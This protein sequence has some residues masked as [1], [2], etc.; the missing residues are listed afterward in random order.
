[1]QYRGV[2]VWEIPPSGQ[3][4]TALLA[5][6]ILDALDPPLSSYP[7]QSVDYFHL[8]I[9]A[10][11]LA[12]ADTR[13][14]IADPDHTH[15]P[16]DWLLSPQYA[17]QRAALLHPTKATTDVQRGS[18]TASSD[19]VSF[20]AVDSSGNACSFINSKSGKPHTLTHSTPLLAAPRL[21][22]LTSLL[23]LCS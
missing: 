4:L 14:Y 19:T 6:N 15:V 11:R 2:D 17:K 13:W 16:I 9:E 12:F 3:G 7:A 22:A 8:Q 18:P 20:C 10:M 1:M 21:P 23:F 5:L